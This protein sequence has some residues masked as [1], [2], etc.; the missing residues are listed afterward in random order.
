MIQVLRQAIL[1]AT[2][3]PDSANEAEL[4]EMVQTLKNWANLAA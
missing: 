4:R 3:N 2:I 1:N